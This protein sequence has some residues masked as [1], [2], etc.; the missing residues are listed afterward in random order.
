MKTIVILSVLLFVFNA[1]STQ[2]KSLTADSDTVFWYKYYQKLMVDFDFDETR[3]SKSESL[4]RYWDGSRVLEL[5]KNDKKVRA[6]AVYF[7]RQ[8]NEN[9]DEK[10]HFKL[11]DLSKE[12]AETI[13]ALVLKYDLKSLPS[14]QQING[15]EKG[16]GGLTYVTEFSD[17]KN[18]SFKTYWD[19]H[20]QKDLNE[21]SRLLGFV[22]E[23]D[24]ITE[25][26]Q[27]QKKFM[28]KQP[29]S[30]WYKYISGGEVVG[31]KG[32]VAN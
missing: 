26:D 16:K 11:Q 25:L 27:Q 3:N 23:I 5:T 28:D 4:F 20:A 22:S 13:Y 14:G 2:T 32:K 8:Y 24:K 1:A 6:T 21:A 17:D 31:K 9:Q 10:L 19:P 7:L 12:T 30:K 29:F 15:W 18:Y